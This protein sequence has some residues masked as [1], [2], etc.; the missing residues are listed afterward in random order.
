LTVSATTVGAPF[1]GPYATD[2]SNKNFTFTFKA[3][4]KAELQVE[5]VASGVT[6][7]VNPALYSA[8]I[9]AGEGGTV[10]YTAAPAAGQQVYIRPNPAFT[11][12]INWTNG[13][14]F[15]A[16]TFNEEADRGVL[17]DLVLLEGVNSSIRLPRGETAAVLPVATGRANK[18]PHFD[19]SGTLQLVTADQLVTGLTIPTTSAT[20]T[21][22]ATRG[23]LA[24]ISS[25]I[26]GQIAWL[27]EGGRFGPFKFSTANLSAFV[28][29]DPMQGVYVAPAS[30]TSGASGA[31][32]RQ[33][34][35]ILQ[36]E[37]FGAVGD[38]NGVSG[39]DNL[40]AFNAITT[41]V[42][43]TAANVVVGYRGGYTVRFGPGSFYCSDTWD[44]KGSTFILEGLT[45]GQAGGRTTEILFAASK[46]GIRLQKADTQGAGEGSTDPHGN[47]AIVIRNLAVRSLGGSATTTSGFGIWARARFEA[48]SVRITGFP[49]N[50]WHLTGDGPAGGGSSSP[51][52]AGNINGWSINGGRVENC[53]G[54]GIYVFGDDANAGNCV[55]TD[56]ASLGGWAVDDLSFLGNSYMNLQAA[57]CLGS[58]KSEVGPCFFINCYA[59]SGQLKPVMASGSAVIGGLFTDG[60]DGVW[61]RVA[62]STLRSS[63]M[64]HDRTDA[65]SGLQTVVRIGDDP[66]GSKIY[67]AQITGTRGT[68]WHG[69]GGKDAYFGWN[70]G[71]AVLFT[72]PDTTQQ[73]GRGAA[74]V[75]IPVF[76]NGFSFGSYGPIWSRG[77]AAPGSGTHARSEIVWNDNAT[78]GGAVGFIATAAGTP[79]TW[80]PF[81]I[82]GA[83]Q[84]ASVALAAGATPTKAEFDALVTSLKNAKLMA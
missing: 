2:G 76:L 4:T 34:N 56:F 13:G 48:H 27:F 6:T 20:G 57:G 44:V 12:Q 55:G 84:A 73:F 53:G 41:F 22:V 64:W 39:T 82:V 15:R 17:R 52:V 54:H 31:W 19:G 8:T 11:Q 18:T 32:V 38:Y 42:N 69:F 81:G 74:Q 14:A 36:A 47:D 60:V 21:S 30:A 78:V 51:A 16:E 67:T 72:G 40:G 83:T 33:H 3:F 68:F 37:W 65:G 35:G 75:N 58:Y 1:N 29:A 63:G 50:G 26:D 5:Q 59:E 25:P 9:N 79:G 71:G 45:G 23:A 28:T 43:A 66:V 10:V 61:M 77:G 70:Q 24:G 49:G 46:T 62:F 80:S 7:I